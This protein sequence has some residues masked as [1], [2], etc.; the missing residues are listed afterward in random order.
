ME[1]NKNDE[2]AFGK[3]YSK[4]YDLFYSD[5]DYKKECDFLEKIFKKY[6]EKQIKNILDMGCGTGNHL[7][8][9]SKRGYDVEGIDASKEMALIAEKKIRENNIQSS[10]KVMKFQELNMGKKFD[11]ILCMFNAIDYIVKDGELLKIFSKVSSHL[12]DGGIFI[13]DF[14][15][16]APSLKN[17]DPKRVIHINFNGKDVFRISRSKLDSTKRIFKTEYELFIINRNKMENRVKENH[18]IKFYDSDEMKSYLEKS[19]LSVISMCP[20]L[21]LERE[22][23]NDK[24]W[25]IC[26]IAKKK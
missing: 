26:V 2:L 23:V 1:E 20:F 4:F 17:Y 9:L 13:F 5:K 8:E 18:V 12:E 6:S 24:D 22:D 7:I 11:A 15:N 25:N 16:S 3:Q 19:E 21:E 14:R 10:V